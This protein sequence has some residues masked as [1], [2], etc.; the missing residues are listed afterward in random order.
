MKHS[1]QHNE[2]KRRDGTSAEPEKIIVLTPNQ[3]DYVA[4]GINPQPLPP[5]EDPV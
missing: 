2:T 5:R 1:H 3:L 4:G